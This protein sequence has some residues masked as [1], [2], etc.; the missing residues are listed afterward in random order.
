MEQ[1]QKEK[2]T[3]RQKDTITQ[4]QKTLNR[5]IFNQTN[6]NQISQQKKLSTVRYSIR[7]A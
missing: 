4:R 2:K 5:E 1:T 6:L 3:K 7:P